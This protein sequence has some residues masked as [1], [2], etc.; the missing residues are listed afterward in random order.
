LA[1]AL[2]CKLKDDMT[3]EAI[4]SGIFIFGVI[5]LAASIFAA[6]ISGCL[7]HGARK[8]NVCLMQPWIVLTEIGLILDIFNIIKA[9]IRLAIVDAISSVLACVLG[10][11][12]FL[13]VWSFK[14]EIEYETK[15]GGDYQG[16]V[17]YK[18][19]ERGMLKA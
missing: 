14:S 6:V 16:K 8:R 19:E 15:A 7:V 1:D 12:L 17:P 2:I 3:K 18:R 13:I 11:Y 10:A 9:L 4:A 5:T